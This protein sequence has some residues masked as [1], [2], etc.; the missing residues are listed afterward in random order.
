MSL[1]GNCKELG[2]GAT[3]DPKCMMEGETRNTADEKKWKDFPLAVNP[4]GVGLRRSIRPDGQQQIVL[5]LRP[6]CQIFATQI[7]L[8]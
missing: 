3:E 7:F 5:T 1:M 2:V 8:I 6:K 4:E